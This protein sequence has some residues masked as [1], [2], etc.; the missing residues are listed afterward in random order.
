MLNLQQI[1]R[2][3]RLVAHPSELLQQFE[4]DPHVQ[5]HNLF[6]KFHVLRIVNRSPQQAQRSQTVPVFQTKLHQDLLQSGGVAPP[7]AKLWR[8]PIRLCAVRGDHQELFRFQSAQ[9]QTYRAYLLLP[10][11]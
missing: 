4:N 6:R 3:Q 10:E 8:V 11:L 5:L 1:V 7:R 9:G 2:E